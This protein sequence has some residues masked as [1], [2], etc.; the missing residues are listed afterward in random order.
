MIFH[1][2]E[3]KTK[4]EKWTFY[5]RAVIP[6]SAPHKPVDTGELDSGEIWKKYPKA[7]FARWTDDYDCG[8]DTDWWY[9]VCDT[10][11]DIMKLGSGSRRRITRGLKHFECKRIDPAEYAEEMACVT[12]AD[13]KSYP[14]RDRPKTTHGELV[15]TYRRW[16]LITHGAFN[17][18]GKLCAFHGMED[19]GDH[20]VMRSGKSVPSEQKNQVNA[21]LIYTY[22]TDFSCDIAKGKY[23]TNG[24]RNL[25]HE[26]NFDDDLCAHYGF[27]KVYCTLRMAFRPS[28]RPIVNIIYPVRKLFSL[29][30][31]IKL[32]HNVNSV[33]KM[34]EIARKCKAKS[35]GAAK[36]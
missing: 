32:F 28:I 26:T 4:M 17:P 12:E 27:R 19:R 23:I 24:Q 8:T 33:L 1:N 9:I 6:T 3:T 7:L 14:V 10:P 25:V 34:E 30:D 13:W 36:E 22:V 16:S 20:Y 18:E 31:G 15:E 11:F 29:F 5:N 35:K 21:A 2:S